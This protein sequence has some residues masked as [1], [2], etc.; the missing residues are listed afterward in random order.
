MPAQAYK[1]LTA[2]ALK[3]Q[4]GPTESKRESSEEMK[5]LA[6]RNTQKYVA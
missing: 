3:M 6:G 4:R 5:N 1:T 2:V